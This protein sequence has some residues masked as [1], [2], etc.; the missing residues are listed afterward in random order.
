ME[1]GLIDESTVYIMA[2]HLHS[3]TTANDA[4]CASKAGDPDHIVSLIGFPRD[5][6]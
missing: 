6:P 3:Y 2:H 4:R 5:K 1:V